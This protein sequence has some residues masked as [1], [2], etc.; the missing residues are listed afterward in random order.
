MALNGSN[1]G[2]ASS[3][4]DFDEKL[5]HAL[6]SPHSPPEYDDH[7]DYSSLPPPVQMQMQATAAGGGYESGSDDVHAGVLPMAQTSG[8]VSYSF[9]GE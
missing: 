2:A 1:F 7:E 9:D 4:E 5:S 6:P 3:L 8:H